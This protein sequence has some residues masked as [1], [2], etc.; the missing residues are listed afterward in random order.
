MTQTIWHFDTATIRWCTVHEST[1][2]F[3]DPG[4]GLRCGSTA[5]SDLDCDDRCWVD[6]T[7][8]SPSVF[9]DADEYGDKLNSSVTCTTCGE[10]LRGT[11]V[12]D[13]GRCLDTEDCD[14][15]DECSCPDCDE[16]ENDRDG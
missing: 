13:D 5:G 2:F 11:E 7:L 3:Y 15:D 9:D 16:D 1:K 12:D 10:E 6:F 8:E 4:S 14:D